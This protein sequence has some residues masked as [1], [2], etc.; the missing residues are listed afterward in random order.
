MSTLPTTE[1]LVCIAAA[2][3]ALLIPSIALRR[4]RACSA[5]SLRTLEHQHHC[6]SRRHSTL[7]HAWVGFV[8]IWSGIAVAVAAF[9]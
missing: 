4:C 3:S 9:D 7:Y 8:L 2:L 5:L 6:P 1:V